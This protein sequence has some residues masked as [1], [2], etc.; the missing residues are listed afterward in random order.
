MT[1]NRRGMVGL[2]YQQLIGG[3]METHFRSTV[4]G[5][6]WDDT[7]LA[8]TSTQPRSRVTMRGSVAVGLH[9]YGE[10]FRR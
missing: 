4:D 3:R 10:G 9:F 5:S 6:N 8:R 7:I 2:L 1:I